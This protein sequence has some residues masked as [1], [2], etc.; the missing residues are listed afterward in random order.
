MELLEP[1]YWFLV[2]LVILA[3]MHIKVSPFVAFLPQKIT[4]PL[5]NSLT[6]LVTVL[7]GLKLG[8]M[9]LIGAE[10]PLLLVAI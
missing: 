2:V 9:G 3:L 7:L 1:C 10:R 8:D 5:T 4:S 6:L